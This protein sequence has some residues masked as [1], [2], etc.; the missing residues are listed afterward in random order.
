VTADGSGIGYPLALAC[1][2][3]EVTLLNVH[4]VDPDQ[5]DFAIIDLLKKMGANIQWTEQGLTLIGD[6]PLKS[7]E[8][9]A[10]IYP[11]LMLTLSFLA[12]YANGTSVLKKLEVLR[13]KESDR[14]EEILALLKQFKIE[15][16]YNAKED[17]LTI[18]GSSKQVGRLDLE[19]PVDHRV[20]MVSYLFLRKNKGGKLFHPHAVEKSFPTFYKV[21]EG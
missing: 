3:G 9:D 15:H 2:G 1:F 19:P 18:I 16:A 11:D 21:M 14:L 4:E 5:A 12:A 7:F 13:H 17:E 6:R 8:A 20:V 10:S